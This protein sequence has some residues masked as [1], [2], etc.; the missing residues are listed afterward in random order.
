MTT[1]FDSIDL[2]GKTLANRIS[3]APMTRRRA[4]ASAATATELMATYYAQRPNAGLIITR[5]NT[6]V[7]RRP[8]LHQ[9]PGLHSAQQV[10]AWRK[11]TDA[12]HARGGTIFAQLMHTG[13]ISH[14]SLLPDG[15]IPV[16]PS[17]VAAAGQVFTYQGRP[18]GLRHAQ[19]TGPG[20]HHPHDRRLRRRFLGNPYN[21]IASTDPAD[22]LE[23]HT[24]LIA[25]LARLDLA[26][27]H[28]VESPDRDL[29]TRLREDRP[30]AFILNPFTTA[31]PPA[32]V[33]SPTSRTAPRTSSPS[34]RCSPWPGP[35]C[36]T[37][38]LAACHIQRTTGPPWRTSS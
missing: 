32:P 11:V 35:V 33:H 5:V 16:A 14:P 30:T 2:S 25:A 24:T 13:R 15:L 17:P 21:D 9:H 8:G 19:R 38:T 27:L 22:V 37:T 29:T 12:V 23:T 26:Y 7:G 3:M 18:P 36:P 34:A 4:D 20:R 10:D 6:A 28:L 31:S 1:V